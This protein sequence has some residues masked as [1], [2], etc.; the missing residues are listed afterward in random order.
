LHACVTALLLSLLQAKLE[1]VFHKEDDTQG[2]VLHLKLSFPDN[3]V[4]LAGAPTAAWLV[5]RAPPDRPQL[6][7][8]MVWQNKTVTRLPEAM[9]LRF[10]PGSGAVDEASWEMRK[11]DSH[12]KPQEVRVCKMTAV[13]FSVREGSA[14][15]GPA[16]VMSAGSA[17][18]DSRC[19]ACGA[20][21]NCKP[22]QKLQPGWFQQLHGTQPSCMSTRCTAQ[23]CSSDI[24]PLLLLLPPSRC[25]QIILNGSRALH[26]VSQGVS[27]LSKDHHEQLHINTLD[28]PLFNLGKPNPFPNPCDGPDMQ[29]GVSFNIVNTIWGTNYAM[30]MYN[31]EDANMVFRFVLEAK[32]TSASSKGPQVQPA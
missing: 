13:T 22:V 23:L 9:W 20:K 24:Q 21:M 14:A 10:R 25:H 29:H 26:A 7:V 15:T 11:L 2:L 28:V 30:W 5:L 31:Q 16:E 17:I 18:A 3:L 1:Q 12:I 4:Q 19:S 27:V 6:H 32:R 8:T